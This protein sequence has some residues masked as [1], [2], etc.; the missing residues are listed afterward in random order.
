MRKTNRTN[1]IIS[2]TAGTPNIKAGCRSTISDVPGALPS[3]LPV[4]GTTVSV[5]ALCTSSIWDEE[6]DQVGEDP[7]VGVDNGMPSPEG[8]GSASVSVEPAKCKETSHLFA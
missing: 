1:R 7:S 5:I 3:A 8:S 6:V 4:S 2:S